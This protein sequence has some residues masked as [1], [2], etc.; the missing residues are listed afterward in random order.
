MKSKALQVSL[1]DGDKS[2]KVGEIRTTENDGTLF[3]LDDSLINLGPSRPIVSLAW[4]D[5][6]GEE[7]TVDRL[8]YSGD[9]I[10]PPRRLPDWFSGLLPEGALRDTPVRRW[11]WSPQPPSDAVGSGCANSPASTDRHQEAP[12]SSVWE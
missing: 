12:E 7:T 4:F 3:E 9:K 2:V 5:L 6:Q 10:G 11:Q 8:R 1:D